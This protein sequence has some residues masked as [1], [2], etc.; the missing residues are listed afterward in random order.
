MKV[1]ISKYRNHWISPY[2][3]LEKVFFWREIDYDEPLIEKWADR[4]TPICQGLQSFLDFVHPE[5]RYVKIDSYDTWNMDGTLSPIILPMLKQLK[6]TKHGSGY[7]DLEDVP[8]HLRGTST[9]E[10]DAQDTFDFYKENIP[11]GVD[12][13]VRYDWALDEMIWTF[14]Q[15]QPDND[16]EDQYWI[17]K[18]EFD[19]TKHPEDEGKEVLPIRWKQKGEVD[20]EG[21]NKHQERINNGLRLFGKYYQTL[22]D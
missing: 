22:W 5:I 9:E 19:F 20:W 15:L 18:P 8:E 3:I 13:H 12:I 1:Y 2:T 11:E 21:R 10:W 6:A 17:R 16:W 7:I 4:L 14:E